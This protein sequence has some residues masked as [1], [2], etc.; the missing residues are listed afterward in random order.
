M[1]VKLQ[2]FALNS[3]PTSKILLN[4]LTLSV[5]LYVLDPQFYMLLISLSKINDNFGGK[6]LNVLIKKKQFLSINISINILK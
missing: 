5:Q 4:R 2:F 3:K 1:F 6:E